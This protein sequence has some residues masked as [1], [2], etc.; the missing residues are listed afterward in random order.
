[1][2]SPGATGP[3]GTALLAGSTV[4]VLCVANGQ[5]GGL[6]LLEDSPQEVHVQLY[7]S[8]KAVYRDAYAY[9]TELDTRWNSTL[10]LLEEARGS[11][12]G[13]RERGNL[14]ARANELSDELL[15][16]THALVGAKTLWCDAGNSLI[17]FIDARLRLLDQQDAIPPVYVTLDALL[18]D[19]ETEMGKRGRDLGILPDSGPCGMQ[20][21]PPFPEVRIRPGD[22]PEENEAKALLLEG[23]ASRLDN[24]L[25]AIEREIEVL[26]N[27]QARARRLAAYRAEQEGFG[28]GD[29][30]EDQVAEGI[31]REEEL[32][33]EVR[34]ENLE[35]LKS[36]IEK[37]KEELEARAQEFRRGIGGAK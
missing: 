7:D 19:V 5:T 17:D 32:P 21:L 6:L 3:A 8:A 18:R 29:P 23:E 30:V 15:S 25:R 31:G 37:H 27:Q 20:A 24:E 34:I 36:E 16:A 35:R 26:E 10:V 33:V 13:A 28:G 11:G 22:T 1:M 12:A 9:K 4:A 14:V 2:R